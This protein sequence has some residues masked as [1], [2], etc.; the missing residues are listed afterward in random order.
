MNLYEI[1]A[2]QQTKLLSV[3]ESGDIIES[4][5]QQ[6]KDKREVVM[7]LFSLYKERFHKNNFVTKSYSPVFPIENEFHSFVD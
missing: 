3:V 6:A 1:D 7:E 2:L 4:W 5:L